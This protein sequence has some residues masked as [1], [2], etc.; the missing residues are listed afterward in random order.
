MHLEL[1]VA[2]RLRPRLRR[3]ERHRQSGDTARAE[4]SAPG[5]WTLALARTTSSD[6]TEVILQP[7]AGRGR[8]GPRHRGLAAARRRR[9]RR[10]RSRSPCSR[11]RPAYPP[12]SSGPPS[13]PAGWRSASCPP[14]ARA[15]PTVVSLDPRLPA[16][17]DQALADLAALAH[18]RPGPPRPRRRRRRGAVVHDAV[19]SRLAADGLDDAALRRLPRRRRAG[20]PRRPAGHARTTR[21]PRSSPAGSCTSCGATAAAARSRPAAATTARSTPRRSSS[22]SPP[23]PGGGGRSTRT[24]CA[25]LAPAVGRAVDWITGPGD[26]DGDGFVDYRRRDPRGPR[27]PGL[28]GLLGRHHPRRR[29]AARR[30]PRP[31]RGAGL[32]LRRPAGRGDA[33]RGCGH[34]PPRRRPAPPRGGAQGPVQ[35]G[36]LG[37]ARLLRPRPGRGRPAHRLPHHEPRA[38]AVVRHR[39]RATRRAAT[40]S[41]SSTRT[42]G[43]AGVCAPW[44]GRWRRTTR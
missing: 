31:R 40:S 15:V 17:V 19:R 7:P 27:Q 22:A 29:H 28:E 30:A 18:R 24:R 36:L 4:D 16:A 3:Q 39:R 35:R 23:R 37:P 32:R 5:R 38:R 41:V 20:Q 44:P 25:R 14:G 26:S 13:W 21:R 1:E 9:G 34:R 43:P 6:R 10:R 33:G 2:R 11:S 8:P 42:C 12:T